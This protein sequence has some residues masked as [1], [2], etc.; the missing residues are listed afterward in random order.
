MFSDQ[1]KTHKYSG[2][3][4]HIVT[5]GLLEG[6]I[7]VIKTNQLMSKK[8]IAVCFQ[9]YRKYTNTLCGQKGELLNIKLVIHTVT[10]GLHCLLSLF[11]IKTVV[12]F[13]STN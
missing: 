7:P 13:V 5:T 10:T 12:F 3:A 8:I 11:R 1:H 2:W 6:K 9:I 4:I